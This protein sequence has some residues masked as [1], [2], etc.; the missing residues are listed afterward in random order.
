MT[1][2]SWKIVFIIAVTLIAAVVAQHYFL[3]KPCIENAI[4]NRI[5]AK[6]NTSTN[7]AK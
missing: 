7:T 2:N 6:R 4:K 3:T 1:P 5:A